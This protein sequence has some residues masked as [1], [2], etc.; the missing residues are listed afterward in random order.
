MKDEDDW[1]FCQQE[2]ITHRKCKTFPAVVMTYDW[3]T[4]NLC[5]ACAQL[6]W[7]GKLGGPICIQSPF[8]SH[9]HRNQFISVREFTEDDF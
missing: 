5:N 6:L 2:R 8:H 7:D 4:F 9:T 3:G 1:R